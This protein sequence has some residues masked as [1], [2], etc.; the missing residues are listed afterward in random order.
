LVT[1]GDVVIPHYHEGKPITVIED[2][3]F[4]STGITSVN[5]PGGVTTIG[6]YAFFSTSLA[7][8]YVA[9]NNAVYSSVDGVLYNKNKTVLHTYPAGKTNSTFSIPEGVTSISER[10]FYECTSLNSVNI[11]A[12]VIIINDE[13]FFSTS[14]AAIYVASNNA[15][16]S[17]VDGVLYD[18]NKT[19]LHTYPAKKTDSTFSI[20]GSVTTIGDFAFARCNSLN[21]VTIPESV[22]SIGY[23]A[24][25]MNSLTSVTFAAGNLPLTIG[26]YAF[27]RCNS[28]N[29]I[30]IPARV[31]FIGYDAFH[32]WGTGQTIYIEDKAN[33]PATI[34]AGWHSG[35]DLNCDPN[36]IIY[37]P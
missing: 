15:V 32:V 13:A 31:T 5:I 23:N 20:P 2:Y 6:R 24:F 12:S 25:T 11:S 28:L 26:H 27:A 19:V 4:E 17:S 37:R 35:W 3:A 30:T 22:I 34:A 21:S 10:A 36:I 7:A 18:K 16:Y 33:R 29:S 9:S 1:S 8:I 14:L